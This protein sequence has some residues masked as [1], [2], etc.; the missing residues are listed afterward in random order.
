MKIMVYKQGV[1]QGYVRSVNYKYER[2][3]VIQDINKAKNYTRKAEIMDEIDNLT[4]F[5]FNQGYAFIMV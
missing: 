1:V 5:S 4:R 3:S 2:F